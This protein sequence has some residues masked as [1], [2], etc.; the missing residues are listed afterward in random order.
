VKI[1]SMH[2]YTEPE[3]G[4]PLRGMKKL[5]DESGEVEQ[6]QLTR[7]GDNEIAEIESCTTPRVAEGVPARRSSG[8]PGA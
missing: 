3:T 4:L 1:Q 6:P 8:R 2:N 7:G 5:K